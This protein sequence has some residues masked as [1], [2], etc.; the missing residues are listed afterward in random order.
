[1]NIYAFWDSVNRISAIKNADNLYRGLY[2]GCLD[3]KSNPSL[4][5]KWIG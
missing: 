4:K 3:L 2:S 5:R 1:M